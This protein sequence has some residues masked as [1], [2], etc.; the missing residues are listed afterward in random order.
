MN[1]ITATLHVHSAASRGM[2]MSIHMAVRRSEQEIYTSLFPDNKQ[3]PS[4]LHTVD[5]STEQEILKFK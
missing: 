3:L 1:H 4:K 5:S 2:H